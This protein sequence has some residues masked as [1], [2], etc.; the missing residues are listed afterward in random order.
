M[1][2][3][4]PRKLAL[5][6]AACLAVLAAPAAHASGYVDQ[7]P[8]AGEMLADGLVVRPLALGATVIGCATWLVT[9]PFSALGGNVDE[10]TQKLVVQPA[11]FTFV[12]P[13]GEF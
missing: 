2:K 1:A 5:S 4:N 12:R 7:R 8:D 3:S 6:L 10:A 13:L 11:A 9:L